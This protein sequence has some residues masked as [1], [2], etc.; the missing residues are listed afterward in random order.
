MKRVVAGLLVH[1]GLIAWIM[2]VCVQAFVQTAAAQSTGTS[3]RRVAL[4]VGNAAYKHTVALANPVNDAHLIAGVLRKTG[5]D[6]IVGVD[7]TYGG[8]IKTVRAFS[9]GL[10]DGDT[11]LFFY[12]GHGVQVGGRNYLLPIDAKLSLQNDL[13]FEAVPL[14][15]V[16]SLM[17][18][19]QFRRTSLVFLDACRNNPLARNLARS[20]G[21]RSPMV[22][23]GLAQ[24]RT[25][26]GT[27]VAFSTQPD[28][29]ALDG[30]GRHSPF[31]A[32]LARRM[33]LSGR[34]INSIMNQVR[35]DV[36]EITEGK[37]VP[38][39]HSAL[40]GDFY[41]VP[42]AQQSGEKGN[43]ASAVATDRW[44][45]RLKKQFQTSGRVGNDPG[46]IRLGET[47]AAPV[48]VVRGTRFCSPDGDHRALIKRV[49]SDAIV[50]SVKDVDTVCRPGDLCRFNWPVAPLFTTRVTRHPDLKVELVGPN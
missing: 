5:F 19:G 33:L 31:A 41:F 29:V 12:A 32:S 9:N 50:F 25:G 38:W 48:Q 30:A 13:K 39:D 35:K 46:C 26:I 17:E 18:S 1:A 43:T 14:E 44:L 7:L 49:Q 11:A 23:Q 34:T 28:N 47:L 10:R 20:M 37:Q 21:T 22:G 45:G 6:V 2:L 40:V 15:L 3:P 42:A 4:V 16:M 24:Q 8:F 27:F 36:V